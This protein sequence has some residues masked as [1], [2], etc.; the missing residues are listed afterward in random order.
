MDSKPDAPDRPPLAKIIVENPGGTNSSSSEV[1]PMSPSNIL[2]LES[3]DEI[4]LAKLGCEYGIY[5]YIYIYMCVC[6][7]L[8]IYHIL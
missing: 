6:V 8:S 1:A 7:A 3:E 5:I 2:V 4:R